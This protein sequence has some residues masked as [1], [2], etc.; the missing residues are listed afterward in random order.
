MFER[1]GSLAIFAPKHTAKALKP[2]TPDDIIIT[3][4]HVIRR[5][6]RYKTHYESMVTLYVW[7]DDSANLMRC[8]IT[9]NA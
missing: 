5:Q 6:E 1:A 3:V 2:H 9:R 8:K 4:S 7:C